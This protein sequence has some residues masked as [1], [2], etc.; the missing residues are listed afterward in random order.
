MEYGSQENPRRRVTDV[1]TD[2]RI[3]DRFEAVEDQ[4]RLLNPLP[5]KVAALEVKLDR[6]ISDM[7]KVD[8]PGLMNEVRLAMAR[9][10]SK[11]DAKFAEMDE[12]FVPRTQM[13]ALYVPRAEHERKS[14]AKLQWPIILFAAIQSLIAVGTFLLVLTH[15]AG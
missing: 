14:Q 7:A 2:E 8:I 5:T 4:L 10:E 11:I 1:W 3:E 15:H 9:T 6:A 12:H 13:P